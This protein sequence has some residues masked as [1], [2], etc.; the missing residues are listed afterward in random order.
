MPHIQEKSGVL[1]RET[2]YIKD[3]EAETIISEVKIIVDINSR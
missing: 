1:N 3:L 2:E